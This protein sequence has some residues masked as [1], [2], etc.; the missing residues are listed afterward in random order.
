ME[1]R[2]ERIPKY[3]RFSIDAGRLARGKNIVHGLLEVDVT[4]A[5]Q[6]MES[7]EGQ[8][9]EKPSFTAYVVNCLGEAIKSDDHLHAYLDWRRR[10]VIY[11]DVNIGTM[12]EIERDGS[13]VPMPYVFKNVNQKDYLAIHQEMRAAQRKPLDTQAG[14]STPMLLAV[15]WLVRRVLYWWINRVPGRFRTYSSPVLVTAVG[16]FGNG[17]AWGLPNSSNTLTVTLGGIALKPAVIEGEIIARE[18]L[19]MT[20]SVNHDIVDGAPIARFVSNLATLIETGYGL[21]SLNQEP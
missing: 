9:G 19:N 13:R 8:T 4:V 20:I 21:D 1:H 11:E 14:K 17:S 5:R 2:T 15:P 7:Y 12:I 6:L 18:F 16:M 3:R 10:L